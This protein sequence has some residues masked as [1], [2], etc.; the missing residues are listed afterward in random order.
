MS[1]ASPSP[2]AFEGIQLVI[3]DQYKTLTE[4]NSDPEREIIREF[5]LEQEYS[6]VEAV[7]CGT[8]WDEVGGEASYL[9]ALVAGLGL[10]DSMETRD[11]LKS[12]LQ[13]DQAQESVVPE[14]A[15]V[16]QEL[17][18]RG[19]QLAILSNAATPQ[20]T[21]V[22]QHESLREIL[23]PA[24]CF[25]SFQLGLVKPDP[26]VFDRIC[27]AARVPKS[28]SLMVGDS[29]RSDFNGSQAAGVAKQVLLDPR[30]E[31]A[32]VHPRIVGLSK[33]LD[34]LPPM[35]KTERNSTFRL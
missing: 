14:A 10:P 31:H 11:T 22:L 4:G 30:G 13:R 32:D 5:K 29:V 33:L 35:Q 20:Y 1:E 19:Y 9:D 3:F 27:E 8:K 16:L 15:G 23:D 21:H 24:L 34:L 17:K 12:I 28:A 7:V 26:R 18:G 25:F 6:Q 2:D